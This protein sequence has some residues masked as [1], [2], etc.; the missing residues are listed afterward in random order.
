VTLLPGLCG[1]EM[2]LEVATARIRDADP[3]TRR[4]VT[5]Y[6]EATYLAHTA[7]LSERVAERAAS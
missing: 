4:I 2:P 1:F 5:R 6:L 7:P 3:E